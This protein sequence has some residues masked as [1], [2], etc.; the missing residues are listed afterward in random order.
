MRLLDLVEQDDRVGPAADRLGEPAALPRSRRSPGA[1]RSAGRRC[2]ARRTRSCRGGPSRS[3]CRRGTRPAPWPARSCPRRS[4]PGTGTSRSAG[5][6]PAGPRGSAGPRRR[7]PGRPRPGS[8]IRRWIWSSSFSSLSRSVVS[9]L[10]TGMP[11]HWLTTSAIS[12]ESTS[13]LSSRWASFG[14][15]VA[16]APRPGRS[17]A[18]GPSARRRARPAP[19]TASRRAAR[20]AAAC[21]RISSQ[22]RSYSTWTVASRSRTFWMSPRPDFSIS[23][24]RRRSWQLLLDLRDLLL[25]LGQPLAGVLLLLVLRASAGPAGAAAAGAGGR[26]SRSGPTAAPSPAGCTP[27]RPG[28]SPCRAGTGR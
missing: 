27:R 13:F 8:T 16:G 25:D 23:H 15:A 19:G 3:R 17:S 18:P 12:S 9:I 14:L 22:A 7:R 20:P 4:G 6:G 5:S 2:A 10:A 1:R 24:W 11:V 21:A 28:R 26:R